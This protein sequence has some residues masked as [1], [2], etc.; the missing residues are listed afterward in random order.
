MV[1]SRRTNVEGYSEE[2]LEKLLELQR[3]TIRERIESLKEEV[4]DFPL[5]T[6]ALA[7]VL[8]IG[9]GIA[10]APRSSK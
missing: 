4:R 6:L 1:K 10:L 7:F 2:D 3:D 5:L 9:I 8:G